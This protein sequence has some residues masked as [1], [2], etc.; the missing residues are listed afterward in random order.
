MNSS[1]SRIRIRGAAIVWALPLVVGV[2]LWPNVEA[3]LTVGGAFAVLGSYLAVI[4]W[5]R[6][7]RRRGE[8]AAQVTAKSNPP[9]GGWGG[10]GGR[11]LPARTALGWRTPMGQSRRSGCWSGLAILAVASRWGSGC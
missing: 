11:F 7:R 1:K 4:D 3:A 5:A 2:W 9:L 8:E 6:E 10:S